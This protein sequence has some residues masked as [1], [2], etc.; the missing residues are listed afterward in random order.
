M[1]T[2]A[3]PSFP[4][5]LLIYFATRRLNDMLKPAIIRILAT[6]AIAFLLSACTSERELSEFSGPIM[7]TTYSVKIAGPLPDDVAIET[8]REDVEAVLKMTDRAMSTYRGDSQITAIN[9]KD[10]EKPTMLWPEVYEVLNAAV[11]VSRETD[12]AFD[13]TVGPLVNLWG[14]GPS[15]DSSSKDTVPDDEE[16]AEALSHTGMDKIRIDHKPP[17]LR[18]LDAF[19]YLDL[20][21]IAKGYAVDRAAE[22]L[23]DY[24]LR[25]YLVEIGGDLKTRGRNAENRPWRIALEKPVSGTRQVAYVIEPG[26][27]AVA[28]SG[29]YRNYFERNGVRYSHTIDPRTG[30]PVTHKVASVTVATSS[31]MRAD[32]LA[33]A[34]LV[35]GLEEGRKFANFK[36]LAAQFV[37]RTDK[38]FETHA[39]PAFKPLLQ[40]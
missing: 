22:V 33:T 26:D 12:G 27:L 34:L 31:G 38:G 25:D 6:A 14:F 4:A 40:E 1:K 11:E 13:I 7:G 17:A 21:G 36:N 3:V 2:R 29:D 16:I 32:A 10:S 20:S 5:S 18:K 30:R 35:M 19:V 39:T 8:I 24:G 28:T 15:H 23:E 9:R 37:V